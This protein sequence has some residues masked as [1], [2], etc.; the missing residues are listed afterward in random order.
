MGPDPNA[1]HARK[2]PVKANLWL[3][4]FVDADLSSRGCAVILINRRVALRAAQDLPASCCQQ[5][6]CG[7]FDQGGPQLPGGTRQ[8]G[9]SVLGR[10]RRYS[11]I[12]QLGE[13]RL[14]R[15]EKAARLG[16]QFLPSRTPVVNCQRHRSVGEAAFFRCGRLVRSPSVTGRTSPPR[17]P[18]WSCVPSLSDRGPH[19]RDDLQRSACRRLRDPVLDASDD[20]TAGR[21]L[22]F[23]R[24]YH[25]SGLA[26]RSCGWKGK[27]IW[28]RRWQRVEVLSFGASL[29]FRNVLPAKR[30]MFEVG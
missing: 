20:D 26:T 3:R 9:A 12:G 25:P 7:A 15:S 8:G 10:L 23:L 24:S 19:C 18:A 21:T 13:E 16:E 1:C 6:P 22:C 29:R 14:R 11:R 4:R 5:S 28:R 30:T 2:H 17:S 27:S